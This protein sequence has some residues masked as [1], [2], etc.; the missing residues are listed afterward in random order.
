MVEAGRDG[1]DLDTGR[2]RLRLSLVALAVCCNARHVSVCPLPSPLATSQGLQQFC[3]TLVSGTRAETSHSG[4]EPLTI[5]ATAIREAHK[6][7]APFIQ[8][9]IFQREPG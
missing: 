7:N 1:H 6:R 2:H 3:R 9:D 4:S 5:I 8:A